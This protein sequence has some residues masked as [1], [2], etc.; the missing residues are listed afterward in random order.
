MTDYWSTAIEMAVIRGSGHIATNV[1][2]TSAGKP[3]AEAHAILGTVLHHIQGRFAAQRLAAIWR[4]AAMH[5]HRLVEHAGRAGLR[6]P[7]AEHPVGVVVR[8][9]EDAALVQQ[10]IPA[11]TEIP[12]HIRIQV[13]PLVWLIMDQAAYASTRTAW[14]KVEH[15][16]T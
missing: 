12:V 13:G 6:N 1:D 10:L 7:A 15:L 11:T 8:I 4:E 3:H 5:T 2:I 9:G 14:D 16:L